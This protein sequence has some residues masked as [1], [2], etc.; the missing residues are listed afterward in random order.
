M[1]YKMLDTDFKL[2]AQGPVSVG[3]LG[4]ALTLV[5]ETIMLIEANG[6]ALHMPEALRISGCVLSLDAAESN[7]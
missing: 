3:E 7:A 4:E 1:R 2:F 5:D 6:N